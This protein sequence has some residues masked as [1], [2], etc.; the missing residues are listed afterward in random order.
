MRL[1]LRTLLAYLDDILD[2]SDAEQLSAKIRESD[3]AS[4]LVHRIRNTVG[5]LR[6]SAPPVIGKG[7][8]ADVNT[9]AEYLDNE[10][11]SERVPDFE[12]VCLES[13][14][15]LAE[16]AACHEILAIVLGEHATVEPTLRERVYRL[17]DASAVI[18]T[19]V[20][21]TTYR[22]IEAAVAS[23]PG[24]GES[25]R[26]DAVE[27]SRP[28][29][30]DQ[31]RSAVRRWW[32]LGIVAVAAVLGHRCLLAAVPSAADRPGGSLA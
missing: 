13:D 24:T 15:H 17:A 27:S 31:G 22:R 18:P 21:D 26:K 20:A 9:V 1:T 3:F 19:N 16:V 8:G 5:R 30:A 2:P 6:L 10:L 32:P 7:L 23:P 28:T 11:P 29:A 14:V 25:A 4:G 12:K